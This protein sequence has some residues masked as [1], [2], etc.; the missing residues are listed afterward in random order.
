M[1]IDI[2]RLTEQEL[3]ELNHRIVARLKILREMRAHAQ[4]LDFNIG[5]RVCFQPDGYP[6]VTGILTKY[7]RKTVS[8]LSDQGQRWNVSP[9]LL[10]RPEKPVNPSNNPASAP[11]LT[12]KR[13]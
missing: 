10:R 11:A 8:V 9:G 6:L 1:A 3:I 12:K 13:P 7:N 4:M 5:D 2:D